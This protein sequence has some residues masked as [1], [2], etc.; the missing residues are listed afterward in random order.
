MRKLWVNAEYTIMIDLDAV[1]A[2]TIGTDGVS[3]QLS[4]G[5]CVVLTSRTLSNKDLAKTFLSDMAKVLDLHFI[6]F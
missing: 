1:Q 4:C 6:T 3:V 5:E 2:V